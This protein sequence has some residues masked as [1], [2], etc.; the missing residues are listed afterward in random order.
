MA[1]K[2][3]NQSKFV[4]KIVA[5]FENKFDKVIKL[6]TPKAKPV[7]LALEQTYVCVTGETA[8]GAPL[9][10]AGVENGKIKTT[11]D[12]N[13]SIKV[14]AEQADGG[15]YAFYT[16]GD[17]KVYPAFTVHNSTRD[18][19]RIFLSEEEKA[20]CFEHMSQ[21]SAVEDDSAEVKFDVENDVENII[22]EGSETPSE[23]AVETIVEEE[24]KKEIDS[25]E[26]KNS[27]VK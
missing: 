8:N 26:N 4:K 24:V 17:S 25:A 18:E 21:D 5:W 12:I 20:K 6:C 3:A 14:G 23:A 10:F 27:E 19:Q 22:V 15:Y 7:E 9:Y 2:K 13:E 1:E 16:D 11:I